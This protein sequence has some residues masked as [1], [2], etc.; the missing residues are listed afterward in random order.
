MRSSRNY[1][2]LLAA[3]LGAELTDLTVSGATTATILDV[4]QSVDFPQ[5]VPPV[6]FAPQILGLPADADLVTITAGGNDLE[7]IGSMLYTAWKRVDPQG[8]IATMM[9]AGFTE[10]IPDPTDADVERTAQGLARIVEAV[11]S[12]ATSARVILVDYLT[13]LDENTP[14]SPPSPFTSNERAA[15]L[16]IRSALERAYVSAAE[17]TGAELVR[18]S[19][20]SADHALGSADPW[21]RGFERDMART[22]ASFHPNELGMRAVARELEARIRSERR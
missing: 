15:F 2:H 14:D 5:S 3:D 6:E 21:V 9:Q 22:E 13:V 20:L 12:R 1:A 10:G 16:R 8:P 19:A 18:M 7:Y 17:R 4:P 11:R